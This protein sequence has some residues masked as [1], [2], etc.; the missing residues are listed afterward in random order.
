MMMTTMVMM[1]MMVMVMIMMYKA[2]IDYV[3][4][5]PWAVAINLSDPSL[6][7]LVL[8]LTHHHLNLNHLNHHPYQGRACVLSFIIFFIIMTERKSSGWTFKWG[9]FAKTASFCWPATSHQ[10]SLPKVGVSIH[11][12]SPL[13]TPSSS[14]SYYHLFA[15]HV[16]QHHPQ[17]SHY[18]GRALS[19]A[20]WAQ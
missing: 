16:N 6:G 14:S 9:A 5:R 10:Q 18:L 1:M 2:S 3:L 19:S 20:H 15:I 4:A 13:S 12:S 8:Y 11:K 17:H 7:R